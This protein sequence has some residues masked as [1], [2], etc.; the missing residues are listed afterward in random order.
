MIQMKVGRNPHEL[1]WGSLIKNIDKFITPDF[2]TEVE[3]EDYRDMFYE[4]TEDE[5]RFDISSTE[6]RNKGETL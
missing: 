3:Y 1:L 2:K 5:F 6:L 4:L